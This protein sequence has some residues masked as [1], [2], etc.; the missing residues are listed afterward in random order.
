MTTVICQV[1]SQSG[2]GSS[3]VESSAA[4]L[5]Q[6]AARLEKLVAGFK[7]AEKETTADDWST[8]AA[9]GHECP[10]QVEESLGLG[11]TGLGNPQAA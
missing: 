10:S 7:V 3:Q 9:R 1:D 11:L 8:A 2:A 5:A 4:A 6:L